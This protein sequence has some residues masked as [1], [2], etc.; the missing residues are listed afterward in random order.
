MKTSKF[1]SAMLIV[2]TLLL[3]LNGFSNTPNSKNS[4]VCLKVNGI[5]LKA[6]HQA[7][8]GSYKIELLKDNVIID[9]SKVPV[10]KQFEFKLVKNSW[11]TIRITKEGRVPLLISVDT[12]IDDQNALIYEFKFET[13]LLTTKDVNA[14]NSI[15]DLPIGIVR[16][17][18]VNNRFYPIEDYTA[19]I[20]QK[21]FDP[22]K[23]K[24]SEN[25]NS[26]NTMMANQDDDDMIVK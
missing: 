6:P 2:I 8:R 1:T 14:N 26:N 13:E 5:I 10:N 17:D 3:C 18:R 23:S 22:S 25:Y 20:K 12:K 4:S 21:I 7:E 11:Y 9:S 15:M 16:F 24:Y 19:D